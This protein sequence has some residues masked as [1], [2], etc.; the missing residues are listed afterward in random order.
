MEKNEGVGSGEHAGGRK[1][2]GASLQLVLLYGEGVRLSCRLRT[3]TGSLAA[4]VGVLLATAAG[5][6]YRGPMD[7]VQRLRRGGSFRIRRDA[8]ATK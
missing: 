2:T 1:L 3:R 6:P 7:V 5:V 4:S 8:D